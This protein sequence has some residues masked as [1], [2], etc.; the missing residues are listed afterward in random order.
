[1]RPWYKQLD[2]G[3]LLAWA[4]LLFFGLV[5]IYSTTHGPAS[6]YLLDTVKRNF[7]RQLQWVGISA[8][9]VFVCMLIP[10]RAFRNLSY[11]AYA[12]GLVLLVVTLFIGR[13]INGAK[14]WIVIGTVGIQSAEIAKVGTLMMMATVLSYRPPDSSLLR[15]AIIT[16]ILLLL[17]ASIVLLQND[18]GSALVYLGLLPIM[19]F[20]SGLPLWMMA[21]MLAPAVA[22]YFSIV[23]MPVAIG[24]SAL[25]TIGIWLATRKPFVGFVGAL[26]TLGVALGA[27]FMM[28]NVLKPH[29]L[30]RIQSFTNP[31]ADEFRSGVGFHLVQSMAAVGSGGFA[32]KGFMQ[33][34]QTQGAY[35]PEQSTDFVF[36]VIAEEF[37]FL[38]S[39]VLLGFYAL[40]L[41]RLVKVGAEMKHPFASMMAAGTAGIFLIH[42]FINVGM[43]TGLLPVI[44]IPLPFV[45]YGGSALLVNSVLMG[46]VLSLHMKRDVFSLYGR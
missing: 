13:E 8:F 32:G 15:Y 6:E 4:G 21:L 29:Q 31:G 26:F 37:G 14:G 3:L 27:S 16:A 22:G 33:G 45:S 11:L 39:V 20:W 38:G 43:V 34:T 1:M 2:Y 35:V 5:A 44:G 17:P 41:L 25:F 30:A 9:V 42:L 19:M 18:T 12:F 46:I 10:A 28:H 23:Y 40:L 36:S 24:F 7:Q